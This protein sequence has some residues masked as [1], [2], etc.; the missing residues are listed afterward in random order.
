M[1]PVLEDE[2]VSFIWIA[3]SN[4]YVVAMART[5]VNAMAVLVFLHALVAIFR[6]YFTELEEESLR[7]NFVIAYELLDEVMDHGYPQFTEGRILAEYIK[8]DAHRLAVQP[9]PPMAVTNAVSWRSEGLVYKKNE[10][11]L[12]V[13]EAVN[14]L[15]NSNGAVVRSEVVGALRMRAYLS[16]MPE[17]KLGLNDR[18]LFEAQG[19]TGRQ[20]AVDLEDIK[21]HQC[22]RLASFERDRTISFIP[23]DG[24]F[25]LMTYRLSQ[26]VKPLIWVECA[27]ERH[28]RSR[29]EYLVKARSQFKERSSA[30]SVEIMLPI[31]PDA[32]SPTARASQVRAAGQLGERRGRRRARV[33]A[34]VLRW[35]RGLWPRACGRHLPGDRCTDAPGPV[36]WRRAVRADHVHAGCSIRAA[37]ERGV[38]AGKG[39]H[40]L[41]DQE[42]SRRS[43]VCAPLQ[44][45][46][47]IRY[48]GQSGCDVHGGDGGLRGWVHMA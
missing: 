28:S 4:L 47:A 30:T 46:A 18:V 8:T 16:G 35:W 26:D 11:F 3:H 29:T 44:V 12:D 40:D 37:G 33:S 27:V 21:F 39:G 48:G 24:A 25:D 7:D 14:L 31:P 17:C 36:S 42:L 22:V 5:N 2:G 41:E 45:W 6:Q 34:V 10:V 1:S 38:R 19:R 23:P 43:R 20:K 13:V 9:R 15:V 32:I